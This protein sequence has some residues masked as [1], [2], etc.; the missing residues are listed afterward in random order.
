VKL[1]LLREPCACDLAQG[2]ERSPVCADLLGD[3]LLSGDGGLGGL[4]VLRA[5]TQ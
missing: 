4:L 3:A 2:F 1:K 5:G